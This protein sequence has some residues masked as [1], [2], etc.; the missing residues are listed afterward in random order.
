M[1]IVFDAILVLII[2]FLTFLGY[3]K[4]LIGTAIAFVSSFLCIPLAGIASVA[5]SDSIG[6]LLISFVVLLII[7]KIAFSV[8]GYSL[9][10]V[11]KI[12][13]I[14]SVN[15]IGGS[16]FGILNGV[17]IALILIYIALCISSFAISSSVVDSLFDNSY[18]CRYLV[19]YVGKF[20]TL[21]NF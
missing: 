4:G 13:I 10:F 19:V 2:A 7:F 11:K 15:A 16:I 17:F 14:K 20:F 5:I 8:L 6:S 21:L 18:I 1:S 3:K 12:P 9:K